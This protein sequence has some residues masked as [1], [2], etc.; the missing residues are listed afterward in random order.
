MS[1]IQGG[2]VQQNNTTPLPPSDHPRESVQP[3]QCLHTKGQ[4]KESNPLVETAWRR[5]EMADHLN[6]DPLKVISFDAEFHLEVSP[7][8]GPA[9]SRVSEFTLANGYG[10]I[11]AQYFVLPANGWR[12]MRKQ[13]SITVEIISFETAQQIISMVLEKCSYLILWGT[14]DLLGLDLANLLDTYRSKIIDLPEEPHFR[15]TLHLPVIGPAPSLAKSMLYIYGALIQEP[16]IVRCRTVDG[17][18]KRYHLVDGS[19]VDDDIPL[20]GHSSASDCLGQMALAIPVLSDII[21]SRTSTG[22]SPLLSASTSSSQPLDHDIIDAESIYFDALEQTHQC[23]YPPA[24]KYPQI[25]MPDCRRQNIAIVGGIRWED[26]SA[27]VDQIHLLIP[28]ARPNQVIHSR[29]MA[30]IYFEGDRMLDLV[31]ESLTLELS[32]LD[33]DLCRLIDRGAA[34]FLSNGYLPNPAEL[35]LF[36]EACRQRGDVLKQQYMSKNTPLLRIGMALGF[37]QRRPPIRP[38]HSRSPRQDLHYLA[39]QEQDWNTPWSSRDTV[40]L[41]HIQVSIQRLVKQSRS[42]A[43]G[44]RIWLSR[45]RAWNPLGESDKSALNDARDG[46]SAWVWYGKCRQDWIDA[47]GVQVK[48]G[49][50]ICAQP[51]AKDVAKLLAS[52]INT[53]VDGDEMEGASVQQSLYFLCIS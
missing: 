31:A 32:N 53:D 4:A 7:Q 38:L 41:D 25:A 50:L 40:S 42:M 39:L 47:P 28:E 19:M 21:N 22:L 13:V 27:L 34:L 11:V 49:Q 30:R 29:L 15:A 20:R 36:V 37:R 16:E 46:D 52:V 33:S 2:H 14:A 35:H 5:L 1:S 9:M 24:K 23:A 6:Y 51:R 12:Y 8:G 44:P 18:F 45:L 3:C 26:I 17:V 10:Q 43:T 48:K